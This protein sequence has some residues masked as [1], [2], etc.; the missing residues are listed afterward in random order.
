MVSYQSIIQIPSTTHRP[1]SRSGTPV[2]ITFHQLSTSGAT[3]YCPCS[4][5]DYYQNRS[6]IEGEERYPG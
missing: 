1:L 6:V 3:A 2:R 4:I 5:G